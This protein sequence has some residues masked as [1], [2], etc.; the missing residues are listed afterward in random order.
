M[1]TSR[2]CGIAVRI[3]VSCGPDPA[4]GQRRFTGQAFAYTSYGN[5]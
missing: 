5:L 4:T 2:D 1:A 3:G